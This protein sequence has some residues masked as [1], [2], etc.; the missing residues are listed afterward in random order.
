MG[1]R[2][3]H[4]RATA[5][6]QVHDHILDHVPERFSVSRCSATWRSSSGPLGLQLRAAHRADPPTHDLVARLFREAGVEVET[7]ELPDTHPIVVGGIP[8]PEGV[9]Q[10]LGRKEPIDLE[11]AVW[12][13][14]R[15]DGKV[16]LHQSVNLVAAEPPEARCGGR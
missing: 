11:D 15:E 14:R 9:G 13:T 7:L 10:G 2:A 6:E 8:A 3:L 1:A 12:V 5:A 16:K 4:G